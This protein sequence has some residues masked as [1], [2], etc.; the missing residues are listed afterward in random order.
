MS[1][2]DY[3]RSKCYSWE[4]LH[5]HKRDKSHVLFDQAQSLVDYVWSAEGLK[6]PPQVKP[7]PKQCRRVGADAT[8]MII[9]IP[10]EGIKTTIL[11]HEMAH[12]MTSNHDHES[13]WHGPRW[14]GVFMQLLS[15][16]AGFDLN[17]LMITAKSA[18]VEFNFKGKVI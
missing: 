18:G 9:R 12:S 5:V 6:H 2:R 4:D 10:S 7:L 16:Y 13:A 8:R 3:Q 15:R 1:F 14:T 11:L 17:E